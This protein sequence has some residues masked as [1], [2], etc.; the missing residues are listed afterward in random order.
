[1]SLDVSLVE[2]GEEVFSLNITHNLGAMAREAGLYQCLWR[3]EEQGWRT[4][5]NLTA[6]MAEGL[7]VLVTNRAE[8]EKHSPENGW[9]EWVNLVEFASLYL[10][11][12]HR[13]PDAEVRVCR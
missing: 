9:G 11:A 4:A 8:M 13:W 6:P 2:N 1:M 7:R 12:C 10:D 3:P 5:C